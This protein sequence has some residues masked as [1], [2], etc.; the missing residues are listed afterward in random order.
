MSLFIFGP[1]SSGREIDV[2]LQ[3]LIEELKELWNFCGQ[4]LMILLSVSSFNY[5]YTCYG[6]LMTFRHVMTYSGWSRKSYQT[7]PICMRDK[8]SFRIRG[9]IE[10]M[11]FP[12]RKCVNVMQIEFNLKTKRI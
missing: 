9:K 12:L 1:R 11:K 6:Q 5:I 7:C 3:L 10:G 4:V 2:Y 8:S